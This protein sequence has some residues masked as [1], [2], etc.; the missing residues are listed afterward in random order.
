MLLKNEGMFPS[1]LRKTE[2]R[3]QHSFRRMAR[4]GHLS[5]NVKEQNQGQKKKT[6]GEKGLHQEKES[7][8]KKRTKGRGK[9][10]YRVRNGEKKQADKRRGVVRE[11]EIRHRSKPKLAPA[12]SWMLGNNGASRM[13]GRGG[14]R[15]A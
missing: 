12:K 9:R 4:L 10:R 2:R 3:A 1:K 15:V 8:P 5:T 14:S 13:G 7:K 11:T 6:V